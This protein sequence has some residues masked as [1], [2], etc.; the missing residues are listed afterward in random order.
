MHSFWRPLMKQKNCLT[1]C[2]SRTGLC[3]LDVILFLSLQFFGMNFSKKQKIFS[4]IDKNADGVLQVDDLVA[5]YSEDMGKKTK[6]QNNKYF[7]WADQNICLAKLWEKVLNRSHT[8]MY[9]FFPLTC[10]FFFQ[11]TTDKFLPF[12][13]L[14]LTCRYCLGFFWSRKQSKM[15]QNTHPH[16]YLKAFSFHNIMPRI[17]HDFVFLSMFVLKW[18]FLCFSP[19]D[20]AID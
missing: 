9:S 1:L 17:I 11:L 14:H 10:C 7:Q 13:P 15:Y 2:K 16:F 3:V 4:M 19:F 12:N 5:L 18:V 20:K 6:K 8:F